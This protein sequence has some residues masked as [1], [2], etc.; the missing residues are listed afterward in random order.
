M[1]NYSKKEIF[2]VVPVLKVSDSIR[3]ISRNIIKGNIKKENKVFVQTPQLS[4]YKILKYNLKKSKK[5][6][7][8]ESSVFLQNSMKVIAID[9][10]P[11]S[12]KIT[13]ETD[14]KLLE[15]HLTKNYITKI[16]NGLIFIGW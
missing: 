4:N 5:I 1:I 10:D 16:G 15:P 6:F 14:L 11:L 9:G 12:L 3:T 8:D 2:C 13:Y 7:E